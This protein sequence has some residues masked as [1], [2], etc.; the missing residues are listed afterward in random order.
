M[1]T[2]RQL[3][4][5]STAI[6]FVGLARGLLIVAAEHND[7]VSITDLVQKQLFEQR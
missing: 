6:S 1:R 5:I 4:K 7:R 2:Q 3:E